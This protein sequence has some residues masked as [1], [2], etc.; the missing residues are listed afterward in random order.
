MN[1]KEKI[2]D[3]EVGT[4]VNC[5]IKKIFKNDKNQQKIIVELEDSNLTGLLEENQQ[6]DKGKIK[7]SLKEKQKIKM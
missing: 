3:F 2:Q 7:T 1:K 5:R 6:S 4:N